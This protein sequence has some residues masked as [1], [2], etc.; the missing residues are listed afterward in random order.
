[1]HKPETIQKAFELNKQGKNVSQISRDLNVP[2]STVRDWIKRTG[3]VVQLAGDNR[4]KICTVS[5]Q[6]RSGLLDRDWER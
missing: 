3:P 1:M 4:L 2:R 5:V 6:I